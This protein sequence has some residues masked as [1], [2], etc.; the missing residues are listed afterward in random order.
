MSATPRIKIS[1]LAVIL[2]A[3]PWFAEAAGL[4]RLNVLSG[5]GQPLRGEIELVSVQ[6]EEADSLSAALASAEVHAAAGLSY[7]ASALGV[8][9]TLDRRSNGAF[10]VLVSSVQAV[11]EPIL[12]LMVDL[13][14]A[15]GQIRRGYSALLDPVGYASS[16]APV[17][18]KPQP[19]A[20][21]SAPAVA[22]LEMAK[23]SAAPI[24]VA[25]V[26][27]APKTRSQQKTVAKPVAGASAVASAPVAAGEGYTVKA[28]DTLSAVGRKVKPAGV[29]LE[30]VLV[31]LYRNNPTAFDGN[32]NL[33]KKGKILN[34]PDAQKMQSVPQAEAVK[35]VLAQSENWQTYRRQL[36]EGVK[37]APAEKP[38]Q[39]AGS[40]KITAKVEDKG[41]GTADKS[42]DVLKLASGADK[43]GLS[44]EQA[45][46][47]ALEEEVAARKKSLDEANQRVA[48]L[49][50]NVRKMEELAA[51]KNQAG[52]DL[53]NKAVATASK[54]V[55]T[56]TP[57]AT[58][59]P[60][61]TAS[62]VASAVLASVASAVAAPV[63]SE[64]SAVVASAKPKALPKP[65]F[66]EVPE[67]SFVDTLLENAPLLGGGLLAALLGAGA[68]IWNRRRRQPS[69]FENSIITGGDLKPNTVIGRTGGGVISTQAENSF[70]TD[71]SRQGFGSIDTDE[72]D[73]IAEA[74]V[75]MAYGRDA[76]AEEILKDAL[77]KDKQ[78]HEVRVKLLDIYAARKDRVAF[79][80]VA[81]E[82]YS[83]TGGLGAHWEHAVHLGRSIDP[84]N[85]LYAGKAESVAAPIA[86]VAAA[87]VL[88]D[89][90]A[91]VAAPAE[92]LDQ[93]ADLDFDLGDLGAEPESEK[94]AEPLLDLGLDLPESTPVVEAPAVSAEGPITDMVLDFDLEQAEAQDLAAPVEEAGLM[95]LDIPIDLDAEQVQ[96]VVEA[97]VVELNAAVLGDLDLNLDLGTEEVAAPQASV[98]LA[99]EAALD[100]PSFDLGLP[101]EA[102]PVEPEPEA[103]LDLDFGFDLGDSDFKP[104]PDVMSAPESAPVEELQAAEVAEGGDLDLGLDATDSD[105]DF[106]PDDPVQTKIDL[107]RAYVDMGDVEGAREIL[108]EALQEGSPAQQ[109]VARGMLANL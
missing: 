17:A 52:A 92:T 108:Q 49:Q 74:D 51:L 11:N 81:S 89:L 42:K 19:E 62:P 93:A 104:E 25:P 100:L 15:T 66:E 41:A 83:M 32:M 29:S 44:P 69:I 76:Q 82:L 80:E 34:V 90:D 20:V 9:L 8:R 73:P 103:A 87:E 96:P 2:A 33:L 99:D 85:P 107:A 4:G 63:A 94:A 70:L 21:S 58:V 57:L 71:F 14:W 88:S 65:V 56:A 37:K 67:P 72:V 106:Q 12:D 98:L 64:A 45:R 24:A 27:Q 35:E 77:S 18:A 79:E 55:A 43:K 59:A 97:P 5:L 109:D 54:V 75:Y 78:R 30:Q 86:A 1:M 3:T 68:F 7:P 28:G 13:R 61:V 10:V 84:V 60:S 16:S 48:E 31:G 53:Q 101:G 22:P 46:V 36:A 23:V 40:G 95:S 39:T 38:A 102:A 26:V 50:K 6:P 91:E 105:L 47:K